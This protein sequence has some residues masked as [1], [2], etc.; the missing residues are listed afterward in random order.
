[1]RLRLAGTVNRLNVERPILKLAKDKVSFS[2]K[3]AA[4][5]VSGRLEPLS[6]LASSIV[7]DRAPYRIIS[8]FAA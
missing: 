1:M 2:I 6:F 5:Q 8:P 7:S 3:L 4:Y